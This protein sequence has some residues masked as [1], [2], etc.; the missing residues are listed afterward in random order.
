MKNKR[1]LL[2]IAGLL[3]SMVVN[4]C[5]KENQNAI[6]MLFTGGYWQ[7]ASVI[8]TRFTGNTA[9]STDTLNTQCSLNQKFTFNINGTCTYQNFDCVAQPVATGQWSLTSNQLYLQSTIT[10]KDTSA[11]GSSKPFSNAQIYNLGQYSMIL[12]T[13]DIQPNYSLTKPR[14]QIQYGFIRIVSP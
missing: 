14:K 7:L 2:L 8:E 11:A 9:D 6:Q 1:S 13:G 10:C 3:A 5:K 4:S 12:I